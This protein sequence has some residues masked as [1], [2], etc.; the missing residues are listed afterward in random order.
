MKKSTKIGIITLSVIGGL[1]LIAAGGFLIYASDYYEADETIQ[2]IIDSDDDILRTD[3]ALIFKAEATDTGVIFYPGAKVE[4]TAYVPLMEE[5]KGWGITCVLI[6]MP[7]N[8]AIFNSDAADQ[9][10]EDM[11]EISSWYIGGHSLGGAFAAR[12]AASN[13]DKVDG[14]IMCAAYETKDISDT[15]LN[16]LSIYGSEDG[17]LNMDKYEDNKK[18]LPADYTEVIIDGGNHGYFGNY[19]EQ[20]GD[21]TATVT[22]E[23]QQSLTS[24][25]INTLIH[26]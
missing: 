17:V 22:R 10:I 20:D 8:L 3:N 13:T 14:L 6:E 12:Y 4:Y 21:G 15:D 1:I 2:D 18:N 26:E 9:Y 24:D 7:Y 25:E 16:V 19:G 5:I 11:T 23:Y